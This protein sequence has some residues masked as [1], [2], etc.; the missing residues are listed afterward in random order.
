LD[1]QLP[2]QDDYFRGYQDS[3]DGMSKDGKEPFEYDRLSYE[4]FNS[5]S[6]SKLLA[7]YKDSIITGSVPAKL[8]AD[9]ETACVYY[10]GYREAFRQI[11]AAVA[12][13][14]IRREAQERGKHE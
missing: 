2:G 3:I 8:G 4:V 9:Y 11:V 5:E 1:N 7:F 13:Y 10:E 6:G 14:P 12:Q